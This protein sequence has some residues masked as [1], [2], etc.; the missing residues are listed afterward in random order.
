MPEL[1]G[2]GRP[3]EVRR[4]YTAGEHGLDCG[5][6]ATG[7][8][9]LPE[10]VEEHGGGEKGGRRVGGPRARDVRC[11]PVDRPVEPSFPTTCPIRTDWPTVTSL[12]DMW[13]YRVAKPVPWSRN[14]P[15]PKR[16]AG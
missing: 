16:A 5:P 2:R 4:P 13:A 7:G 10:V 1:P 11:G 15:L 6:E 14:R 9:G 3:S 8:I 12:A